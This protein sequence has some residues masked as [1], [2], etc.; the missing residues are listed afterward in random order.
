MD[1]YEKCKECG[2]AIVSA[3][4]K[5]VCSGCGLVVSYDVIVNDAYYYVPSNIS[6]SLA[7]ADDCLH[8]VDGTYMG[9][10]GKWDFKDAHGNRIENTVI[11]T[12]LKKMNDYYYR[13]NEISDRNLRRAFKLLNS[14]CGVLELPPLIKRDSARIIRKCKNGMPA[15]VFLHEFVAAS[16]YLTVRLSSVQL[17]VSEL[18]KA[19]EKESVT[20][21]GKRM[22]FAAYCIKSLIGFNLKP[23][24]S[25]DYL[26]SALSKVQSSDDVTKSLKSKHIN[27]KQYM[28]LLRRISRY[29]LA[30]IPPHS[31]GGRDPYALA[32]AALSGA[33]TLIANIHGHKRGYITQKNISKAVKTRE[34]TQREHYLILVKP[35]VEKVSEKGFNA[36]LF[37]KVKASLIASD[38]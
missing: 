21:L 12:R 30:E 7:G 10:Y 32:G 35:V 13:D 6:N 15:K 17:H 31:R 36:P 5:R 8:I 34:F 28:I 38:E 4:T 16:I 24:K 20:V 26:E 19:F 23:C 14:I 37:K 33:D 3:G 11:I 22:L 1:G 9:H 18:L 27:K 25:E 2:S 29:L